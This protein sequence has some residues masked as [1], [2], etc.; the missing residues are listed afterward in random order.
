MPHASP[1]I[2]IPPGGWI[3]LAIVSAFALIS[4]NPWLTLSSLW[5]VPIFVVLLW[6]RH[7]PPILLFAV[8]VQWAVVSTKV[9]HANVV[10][11][12]VADL[13]G[14][15]VVVD[16]IVHGFIG[17]IVLA[18]GMRLALKG[19]PSQS[20]DDIWREGVDLSTQQA[21]QLYVGALILS[22]TLQGFIHEVPGFTQIL[23]PLFNLKWVFF[24]LL[25]FSIFFKR[26]GYGLLWLTVGIEVVVGFSGFFAGFK[27]VFFV[28]AVAY[29][30]IGLRLRGRQIAFVGGIVVMVFVLSV[31][32]MTVRQDYR[33]FV[34][35][36][37]GMQV[38]KAN[39]ES[40]LSKLGTLFL[41][42]EIS[43][44]VDGVDKLARRVAYVDMFGHVLRRVPSSVPHEDGKLWG[45]ALRHVFMPRIL[46]PEKARLR[47]DSEKTM[48][49]TG[50]ALSSDVQGTSISM[51][52]MAESY[53]DFGPMLMYVPVFV[54]GLIWGGMYRYFVTR[55]PPNLVGFAVAVAVL[56][57]ANQF[58]MTATKLIGS[59]LM[60][61]IVMTLLLKTVLPQMQ[62]WVFQAKPSTS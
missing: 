41:S 3:A 2:R 39:F 51:G 55:G 19:L 14:D 45:G 6:R 11:V 60:S 56:V 52:Y 18:A 48:Y 37:T 4:A 50:L 62:G 8:I 34:N 57:N 61:F 1:Y 42:A 22:L 31:M 43:D 10:E 29:M 23:L 15:A 17:L 36:G 49:Y 35:E 54:L 33:N 47:S 26:K 46:F 9:I 27:Q 30:S 12:T 38:V 5:V 40:R 7:E 13:F 53:I 24:Y 25:A 21:W 58:E 20:S 28:L 16:A 44:F 32:W 59:M